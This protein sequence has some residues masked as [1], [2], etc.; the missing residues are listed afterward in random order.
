MTFCF[1]ENP[2]LV[3]IYTGDG[4]FITIVQDQVSEQSLDGEQRWLDRFVEGRTMND[5]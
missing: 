4:Q 2:K 3:G 1:F 5:V